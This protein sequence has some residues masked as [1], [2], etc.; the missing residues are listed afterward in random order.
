[1]DAALRRGLSSFLERCVLLEVT[2]PPGSRGSLPS[3]SSMLGCAAKGA[4][5]PM[6]RQ[7]LGTLLILWGLREGRPGKAEV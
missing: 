5:L 2:V 7:R 6:A 3:S 4:G 1:M